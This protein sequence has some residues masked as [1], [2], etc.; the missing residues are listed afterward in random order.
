MFP[1]SRNAPTFDNGQPLY[2]LNVGTGKDLSIKEL[3]LT[4]SRLTKFK[5]SII[6]DDSKPNG[7][8][9]KKLDVNRINK[10]GWTHKIKLEDG[11][12]QTI[13]NYR[14]YYK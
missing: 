3:A 12:K 8:P 1:K 6:W 9:Q 7:T 5:G 2:H 11:I 4:I 14:E 10:L 13:S